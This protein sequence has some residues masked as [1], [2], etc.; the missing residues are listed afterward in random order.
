MWEVA[1]YKV[2]NKNVLKYIG[3]PSIE[4]YINYHRLIWMGKIG[5]M[6]FSRFPPKF[7]AAWTKSPPPIFS[8]PHSW[9]VQTIRHSFLKSLELFKLPDKNGNLK[10]WVHKAHNKKFW[11]E[12]CGKVLKI[13]GISYIEFLN[14][15]TT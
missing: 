6:P 13:E 2:K 5:R 9:P 3:I 1:S 14:I 11:T 7:L 8:C 15:Y 12:K 4:N 10:K